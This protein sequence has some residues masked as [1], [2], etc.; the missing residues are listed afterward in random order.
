MHACQSLL[1][2]DWNE[3]QSK[4]TVPAAKQIY[5]G[6]GLAEAVFDLSECG[7]KVRSAVY[8]LALLSRAS[9]GTTF[10]E[11]FLRYRWTVAT[12]ETRLPVLHWLDEA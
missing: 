6:D 12:S 1:R 5:D 10:S 7:G 9:S 3:T 11:P 2:S 8:R 4:L